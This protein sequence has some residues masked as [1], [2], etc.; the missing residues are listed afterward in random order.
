MGFEANSARVELAVKAFDVG[1]QK[2]PLDFDGQVADAQVKQL[3][4]A[5][6][7]R[8][9]T[10]PGQIRADNRG[11]VCRDLERCKLSMTAE[12]SRVA[13]RET[14][15]SG[16]PG[17]IKGIQE[18]RVPPGKSNRVNRAAVR[19]TGGKHQLVKGKRQRSKRNEDGHC[20]S[21]VHSAHNGLR[22]LQIFRPW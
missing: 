20:F 11:R 12:I 9:L 3:F 4:V 18:S 13:L 5:E 19:P 22:A 7:M 6:T 21:I 16:H 17:R 1:L 14:R 15:L 2:R 8:E 10:G